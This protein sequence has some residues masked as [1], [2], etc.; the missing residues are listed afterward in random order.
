M[1]VGD[2]RLQDIG[3]LVEHYRIHIVCKRL[4]VLYKRI[5]V[6]RRNDLQRQP[7]LKRNR[8]IPHFGLGVLFAFYLRW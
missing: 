4:V 3:Q 5:Q 8:K 2:C 1:E 6:T 7:L